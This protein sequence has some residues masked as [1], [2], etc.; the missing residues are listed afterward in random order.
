MDIQRAYF[1]LRPDNLVTSAATFGDV[2]DVY[3][4]IDATLTARLPNG[5][6]ASGGVSAGRERTDFCAVAPNASM[7]SNAAT[8]AGR[9]GE[10]T[11]S[12]YPSS[13]YC[14]VT[15]PYQP[16]WKGLVSYPLP[17][18]GLNASAT[19]QN[20]PG[21]QVLASY[22]A[23]S[24]ETTLTRP[25]TQGTTTVNFIAPGTQYGDRLNQ[26]D[27]RVAKA[28]PLRRGR[29]QLTFSVFNVFNSNATLT[30]NTRFG[31]SWLLPTSILQGRLA[32]IGAQLT[33]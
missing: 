7:G 15:P 22:V 20:R 24:A 14:R 8:S 10:S 28:M 18:W 26:V 21:P 19:W 16:D 30:W 1:G 3:T 29:L 31:P 27:V 17:W 11:I 4:G 23:T 33:F 2:E 32:K 12:T 6:V 13:L 9:V 5:G 25:L